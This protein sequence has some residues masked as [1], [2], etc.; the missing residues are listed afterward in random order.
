MCQM[1]GL[2]ILWKV[3]DS[4]AALAFPFFVV[5]MIPYR[6]LLGCFF[7]ERELEAVRV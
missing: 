4:P 5:A 1:I 3:K 6:L 2:A 7:S